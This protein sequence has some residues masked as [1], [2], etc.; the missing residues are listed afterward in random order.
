MAACSLVLIHDTA[1]QRI[2]VGCE[3]DTSYVF[4]VRGEVTFNDQDPI[5]IDT[6]VGPKSKVEWQGFPFDWINDYP[7]FELEIERHSTLGHE[8]TIFRKI[9][10]KPKHFLRLEEIIQ[11]ENLP[12]RKYMLWNEISKKKSAP[13][14][15]KTK[16]RKSESAPSNRELYR[17]IRDL[18]ELATIHREVDLHAE[19]LF[20]DLG[21]VP[22]ED[23]LVRQMSVFRE[24]LDKAKRAGLDRVF[25]IHGVGSGRLKNE[26]ARVLKYDSDVIDFTNEYHP[27]YGFGATEVILK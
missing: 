4:I 19:S 15:I 7:H 22:P 14:K 8:Q 18:S 3:N 12:G 10:T 9:K 23:I 11:W 17:V 21:S 26:I 13:I 2:R 20:D 1:Q 25:V 16:K 6:S 5:G 24:Y 27:K